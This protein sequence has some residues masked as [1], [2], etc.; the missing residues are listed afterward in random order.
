MIKILLSLF[1]AFLCLPV[2]FSQHINWDKVYPPKEGLK[3]V[4]KYSNFNGA[5]IPL[6]GFINLKGE[7]VIPCVYDYAE[8]FSNGYALVYRF[9]VPQPNWAGGSLVLQPRFTYINHS[10]KEL[11][12]SFFFATSINQDGKVLLGVPFHPYTHEPIHRLDEVKYQ[13]QEFDFNTIIENSGK[14]ENLNLPKPYLQW[15]SV[16]QNEGLY[17]DHYNLKINIS[18]TEGYSHRY[19]NQ[20]FYKFQSRQF[21]DKFQD[22]KSVEKTIGQTVGKYYY[23][24]QHGLT[25]VRDS[26]THKL[27]IPCMFTG[28]VILGRDKFGRDKFGV[29]Q[30][31]KWAIIDIDGSYLSDFIFDNI[32]R[33]L[34]NDGFFAIVYKKK[35]TYRYG[36]RERYDYS[37]YS[38]SLDNFDEV[39]NKYFTK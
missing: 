9:D 22:H 37:S 17:K 24:L 35:S 16:T 27:V 34:E 12:Y 11:E 38:V 23:V 13:Y 39:I 4:I 26:K 5:L 28:I 32:E 8:D 36:N 7:T 21:P 6:Y 10:G 29:R 18:D 31:D 19:S 15:H 1:M 14:S 3:R 33:L 2:A 25:G 30:N 20:D